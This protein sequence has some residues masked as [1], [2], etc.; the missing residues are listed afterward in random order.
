MRTTDCLG[1]NRITSIAMDQKTEPPPG[2]TAF[3]DSLLRQALP[4]WILPVVAY[5]IAIPFLGPGA[6]F[7]TA[8]VGNAPLGILG[9]FEKITLNPEGHQLTFIW[10]THAVFWTLWVGGCALR[11]SLPVRWL[12]LIWYVLAGA[13]FMSISGCACQLGPGLRSDGNWH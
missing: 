1:Q 3:S 2:S 8:V 11:K 10:V 5:V 13:L 9:W 6:F 7:V 12:D 4:W